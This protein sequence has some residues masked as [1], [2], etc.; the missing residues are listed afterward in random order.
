MKNKKI[1]DYSKKDYDT[2]IVLL[3]QGKYENR[4][5]FA[6]CVN[7]YYLM[8]TLNERNCETL[9][10]HIH[11][12][13][14]RTHRFYNSNE[15]LEFA[16]Y[17]EQLVLKTHAPVCVDCPYLRYCGHLGLCES[18]E[19]RG[20]PFKMCPTCKAIFEDDDI[21]YTLYTGLCQYCHHD[22]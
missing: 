22:I 15:L 5:G 11:E 7:M 2:I 12:Y 4:T 8:H 9:L 10:E 21:A 19:T 14:T 13:A 6:D 1:F 18:E 20:L 16:N 3:I 17:A